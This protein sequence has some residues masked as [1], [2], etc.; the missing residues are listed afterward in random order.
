M[1]MWLPFAI[2]PAVVPQAESMEKVAKKVTSLSGKRLV[3]VSLTNRSFILNYYRQPRTIFIYKN[4]ASKRK[5]IN[6]RS[7]QTMPAN[8]QNDRVTKRWKKSIDT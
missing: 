7:N 3:T 2:F 1:V 5:R 6:K 8:L 4:M